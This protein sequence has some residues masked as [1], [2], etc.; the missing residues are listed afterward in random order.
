MNQ[1]S[2]FHSTWLNVLR[3]CHNPARRRFPKVI[4]RRETSLS[5]HVLEQEKR[6]APLNMRE[7]ERSPRKRNRDCVS[8]DVTAIRTRWDTRDARVV[9][10]H[11]RKII[12]H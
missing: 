10:T 2:E 9:C 11:M 7:Y 5:E 8:V 3:E 12:L 6:D 1:Q 4:T